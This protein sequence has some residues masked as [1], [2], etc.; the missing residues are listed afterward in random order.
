MKSGEIYKHAQFYPNAETGELLPKF[1]LVLALTP[2]DD[3]VA[4][5]LT[6]RPHG[7]R[8]TP[9]CSHGDPYPSYYIGVIGAPLDKKSWLDLR[10]FDDLDSA[11]INGNTKRGLVTHV[12]TVAGQVL[13][14]LMEC[15]ANAEDTTTQQSRYILD[16]L[17]ELRSG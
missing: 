7:R 2:A 4:R 14:D 5:L 16:A 3:I 15:A 17:S 12:A 10:K 1:F 9:P 6:S 11:T 8:E 13:F